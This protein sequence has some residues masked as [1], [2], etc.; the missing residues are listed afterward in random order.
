MKKW[1]ELD[2]HNKLIRL[3]NFIA[4]QTIIDAFVLIVIIVYIIY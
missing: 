3:R 4:V 2:D 1:S